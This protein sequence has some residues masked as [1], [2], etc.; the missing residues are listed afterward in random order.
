MKSA[1][2]WVEEVNEFEIIT[3]YRDDFSVNEEGLAM[4]IRKVQRDALTEAAQVAE[5]ISES[6]SVGSAVR[7]LIPLMPE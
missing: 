3:S 6:V 7:S 5:D 4:L 1:L 2:Q